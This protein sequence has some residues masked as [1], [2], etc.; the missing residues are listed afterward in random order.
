M[1][2][3]LQ[4]VVLNGRIVPTFFYYVVF[5]TLGLVAITTANLVD[6][7]FVGNYVGAEA[8]AV[9][10]LLIPYF[11]VLFA[12]A[13][14]LAIGGS[15]SAGTYIG[16]SKPQQASL[17]FSQSLI[18]VLILVTV[19]AIVSLV[20]EKQLFRMLNIPP[21]L[22]DLAQQYLGVIRWVLIVQ[23]FTMVLYYF[24]R[25]DG[26]AK[27]AT[28]ALVSG[29]IINIV[30]DAWFIVI[31]EHG[32]RGAA[33]ATA[34]AQTVQLLILS[35]YFFSKHR[36]LH[37]IFNFTLQ[38]VTY[39]ARS[40]YNGLSEFVNEISVALVFLLL[41][42]LLIS[43][44]GVDGVAAFSVANYFVFLSIM[45]SYGVADTLHLV[46]SQNFGAKNLVRV[47]KFLHTAL[48]TTLGIGTGIVLILFSWQQNIIA[49]FTNSKDAAIAQMCNEL[50]LSIWPLF[51]INGINIIFSCY[52]TAL[53]KPRPSALI[54][55]ARGLVLP[56]SLL[57]LFYT[58]FEKNAFLNQHTQ[59][60]SFIVALP[61]A[62]W[63][64]LMLAV[65][66]YL[67][68]KPS[69]FYHSEAA[70]FST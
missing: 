19:C 30:L 32:L 17:V 34:I 60:W 38:Q 69:S 41:N 7:A 31:L 52:L 45:L 54:A 40:A 51:L 46:V 15:V 50:L 67:K 24:V 10:T 18:S 43:R 63:A 8:L 66:L 36:S 61:I 70:Q 5:S 12:L 23:L 14:M 6:G 35:R 55:I 49:W 9:I 62:E 26:H 47:E 56:G 33:Y 20:F 3:N 16:D 22:E 28:A 27:L 1:T 48:L 21:Q 37:L 13:L 2:E 42:T 65:V 59:A 11:T 58:L 57:L 4:N 39:I 44:L 64:T 53:Q 25:A 68:H 29:A